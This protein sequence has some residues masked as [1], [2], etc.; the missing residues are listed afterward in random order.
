MS[1]CRQYLSHRFRFSC[2][3]ILALHRK[4]LG[5]T[6]AKN[7]LTHKSEFNIIFRSISY[8]F[9]NWHKIIHKGEN[10]QRQNY[11]L[12]E[13]FCQRSFLPL[14]LM[15]LSWMFDWTKNTPTSVGH[16]SYLWSF[17]HKLSA[18]GRHS[19]NDIIILRCLSNH[20]VQSRRTDSSTYMHNVMQDFRLWLQEV[21]IKWKCFSSSRGFIY[22]VFFARPHI[23]LCE[24]FSYKSKET[25]LRSIF[26]NHVEQ[27]RNDWTCGPLL[28]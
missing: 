4:C 21:S 9:Y 23:I 20:H 18:S 3:F 1:H 25:C 7:S 10:K 2:K 27:Q 22:K 11:L 13:V 5:P 15:V 8:S 14:L 17:L 16:E 12:G 28:H 26:F 6:S 24:L 19:V